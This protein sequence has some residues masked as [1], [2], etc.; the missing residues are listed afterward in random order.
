MPNKGAS[1]MKNVYS[2]SS[3]ANKHLIVQITHVP[4]RI[5]ET[6][7]NKLTSY[8]WNPTSAWQMMRVKHSESRLEK[9]EQTRGKQVA[10]ANIVKETS[11]W[12]CLHY[13]HPIYLCACSANSIGY[14]W[15]CLIYCHEV[16]FNSGLPSRQSTIEKTLAGYHLH[17]FLAHNLTTRF[18]SRTLSRSPRIHSEGLWIPFWHFSRK[19]KL[20][21]SHLT[22]RRNKSSMTVQGLYSKFNFCS[23]SLR[24]WKYLI[25]LPACLDSSGG[26]NGMLL[27]ISVSLRIEPFM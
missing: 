17:W 11:S 27:L 26:E 18:R 24:Q 22:V 21:K 10:V 8:Y 16:Y 23:L 14:P 5:T 9:E 3:L 2:K 13:C 19:S 4:Q 6:E 1:S 15:I 12:P 20:I 7:M 25:S